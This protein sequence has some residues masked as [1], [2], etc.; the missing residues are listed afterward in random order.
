[1]P[2]DAV[3]FVVDVA[4]RVEVVAIG[5]LHGDIDAFLR[6]LWYASLIDGLG[7]WSGKKTIV[8][9]LGDQIDRKRLTETGMNDFD[10]LGRFPELEVLLYTEMLK[11]QAQREGGEF[12]SLLG[13][14]E[15]YSTG[16]KNA[17]S[18]LDDFFTK[19]V[20]TSD[21]RGYDFNNDGDALTSRKDL[22]SGGSG[23]MAKK[24]FAG[25]GLVL[26]IGNVVFSHADVGATEDKY[27]GGVNLKYLN[28]HAH[29]F[30]ARGIG[31]ETELL[32]IGVSGIAKIPTDPVWN[33]SLCD[34]T[35]CSKLLD[36]ATYF[37]SAHTPQTGTI[38]GRCDNHVWCIDTQRS[39]AFGE[40]PNFERS[41]SLKIT[42]QPG[43]SPDP[44]FEVL[45]AGNVRAVL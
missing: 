18:D 20:S 17:T 10:E 31:T 1:M 6:T 5:D 23:T 38:K 37:V 12:Y 25:R 8:V 32:Q 27:G 30:L 14:H 16:G 24:L 29:A 28:I 41:Q 22:F 40:D 45:G 9:Q 44:V 26:K 35:D 21:L 33:R 39:A 2:P 4:E 36:R 13:N 7:N 43:N 19:Y 42:I 11:E 3:N 34:A 15:M